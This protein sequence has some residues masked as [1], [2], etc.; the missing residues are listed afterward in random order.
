MEWVTLNAFREM[1]GIALKG[2]TTPTYAQSLAFSKSVA[3][4]IFDTDQSIIGKVKERDL[5]HSELTP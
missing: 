4:Q 2:S 1:L 5:V 3:P